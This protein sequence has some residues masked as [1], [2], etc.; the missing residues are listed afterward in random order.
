MKGISMAE[1]SHGLGLRGS[2]PFGG[3]YQ[4]CPL[5]G[6][7]ISTLKPQTLTIVTTIHSWPC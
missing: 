2:E 6:T 3:I 5:M 7:S 4:A 1:V